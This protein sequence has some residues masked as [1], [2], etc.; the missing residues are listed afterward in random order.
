MLR[1]WHW[2]LL[3]VAVVLTVTTTLFANNIVNW[4][5][6]LAIL[7]TFNHAQ[8][9]DRLQERQAKMIKPDVECYW[10]LNKLFAIKEVTWIV[11]FILMHNYAAIVGS[12]LFALYPVWR[13]WYRRRPS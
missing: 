8:I 5:T 2:E 9:G 12:V 10:K 11:A 4:I 7:F 1:T 6:L 13:K 3:V